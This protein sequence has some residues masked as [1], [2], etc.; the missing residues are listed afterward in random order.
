MSQLDDGAQ[1]Q[2]LSSR[3]DERGLHPPTIEGLEENE[4]VPELV[5]IDR[6]RAAWRM[7]LSAFIFESL[8]WGKQAHH[9]PTFQSQNASS[10]LH[11]FS[12]HH[13]A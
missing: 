6:G 12:S 9:V 3:R 4:H 11:H 8:L 1:L 7:L 13:L 10:P 2:I 5:P